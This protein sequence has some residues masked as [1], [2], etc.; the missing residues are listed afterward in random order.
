MQLTKICTKCGKVFPATKDHFHAAKLGKY[1]LT[2]ICKGCSAKY[3]KDYRRKNKERISEQNRQY[4]MEN[5]EHCLTV[6]GIWRKR[7]PE[8]F[9]EW[10]ERNKDYSAQYDKYYRKQNGHRI[11]D[12]QS[13]WYH[14]N[15]DRIIRMRAQY[16]KENRFKVRTWENKRRTMKAAL[17]CDL[18]PEDWVEIKASFGYKC[19]YCGRKKSLTQDHFVPLSKGGAFTKDN[20][21]P[22]CLSCNCSKHDKDFNEW[23][24]NHKHYSRAREDKILDHLGHK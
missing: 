15:K 24:P 23:Y 9:K 7:N 13:N 2:A 20:I 16:K 4:Y 3:K 6:R 21:I 5:R 22:A 12:R 19:A 1:G 10:Y 18:T 14:R 11:R 8:Y 17:P